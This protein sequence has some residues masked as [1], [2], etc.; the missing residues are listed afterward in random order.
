MDAL[1]ASLD[2]L[3]IGEDSLPG[4][5][6]SAEK[7]FLQNSEQTFNELTFEKVVGFQ[8]YL[9]KVGVCVYFEVSAALSYDD[10]YKLIKDKKMI[11]LS[12][13]S[14]NAFFVN[15]MTI[16]ILNYLAKTKH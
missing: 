15:Y 16:C 11:S 8:Y 2:A 7:K 1:T 13:N 4:K 14:A 5:D 3:E 9:G 10:T 6:L 12:S